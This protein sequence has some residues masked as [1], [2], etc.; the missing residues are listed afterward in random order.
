MCAGCAATIIQCWCLRRHYADARAQ[1]VAHTARSAF[2][3][4]L[5]A[6]ID[7]NEFT[8]GASCVYCASPPLYDMNTSLTQ[9][10]WKEPCR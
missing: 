1:R 6:W 9:T 8:I 5:Y 2:H 10:V 3:K 7:I 4:A